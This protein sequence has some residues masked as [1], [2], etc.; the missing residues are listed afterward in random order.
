[1][2]YGSGRGQALRTG[3]E[4]GSVGGCAYSSVHAERVASRF[5][6]YGHANVQRLEDDS[7]Q[8]QNP[9]SIRTQNMDYLPAT[10]KLRW[11]VAWPA[12]SRVESDVVPHLSQLLDSN[13]RAPPPSAYDV[14]HGP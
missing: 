11:R 7:T 2:R 8:P 4:D 5:E 10:E 9:S 1:M 3:V 6:D 12:I 13:P 14:S